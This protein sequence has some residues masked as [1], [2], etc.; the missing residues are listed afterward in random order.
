[1]NLDTQSQVHHRN[2]VSMTVQDTLQHANDADNPASNNETVLRE[3]LDNIAPAQFH[4]LY[5]FILDHNEDPTDA[6]GDSL[7]QVAES[8]T[9]DLLPF[10]LGTQD[11]PPLPADYDCVFINQLRV[12]QPINSASISQLLNDVPMDDQHNATQ[13][14]EYLAKLPADRQ[15]DT[16][17][18]IS[19]IVSRYRDA[20]QHHQQVL[21]SEL[22]HMFSGE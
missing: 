5:K 2:I 20:L 21:V 1:M 4:L 10:A 16:D 14:A 11:L 3:F 8:F 7:C 9:A 12:H 22:I 19:R 15:A 6:L 18:M 17:L 13:V